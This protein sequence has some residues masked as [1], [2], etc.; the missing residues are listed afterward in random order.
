MLF[1]SICARIGDCRYGEPLAFG[2]ERQTEN[3]CRERAVMLRMMSYIF[4]VAGL[5]G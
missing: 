2:R 1:K 4:A 3:L 5:L